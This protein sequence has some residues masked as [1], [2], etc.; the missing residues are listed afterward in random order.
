MTTLSAVRRETI[1]SG[2]FGRP[3]R[4]IDGKLS[5]IL[6][7][8]IVM[9]GEAPNIESVD[10]F[11]DH[12]SLE[13][14]R[15]RNQVTD[16]FASALGLSVIAI[17]FAVGVRQLSFSPSVLA[18]LQPTLL[19]LEFLL[20]VLAIRAITL[21]VADYRELSVLSSEYT[22]LSRERDEV[23]EATAETAGPV[24][25]GS[26]IISGATDTPH[27]TSGPILRVD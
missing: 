24:L 19:L 23:N 20:I 18:L 17:V 27:T 12:V 21:A 14:R 13:L 2:N 6:Q 26:I 15:A 8:V 16:T 10:M 22:N 3:N 7:E 4:S 5:A 1:D 25:S 9:Y 11:L